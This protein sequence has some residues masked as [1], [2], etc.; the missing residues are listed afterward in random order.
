MPGMLVFLPF[1]HGSKCKCSTYSQRFHL[2][3]QKFHFDVPK[4]FVKNVY[5]LRNAAIVLRPAI[6]FSEK[7]CP[8]Y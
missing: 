6:D 1:V 7:D 8:S 5:S 2:C 3:I 4:S